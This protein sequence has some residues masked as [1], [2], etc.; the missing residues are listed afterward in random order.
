MSSKPTPTDWILFVTL[1]VTWGTSFLFIEIAL[2]SIPPL[3]IAAG[4]LAIAAVVLTAV[5]YILRLRLPMQGSIWWYFLVIGIVGNALPFF[6]IS[7]GQQRIDSGLAG[8]LI[9]V[10]PL[11][12]LVLA[13][14]FIPGEQMTSRKTFGFVVGFCG[15]AVMMG[16]EALL[17]LGGSASALAHQLAV[18]TAALCYS[19]NAIVARRMPETHPIVAS[20]GAMIMASIVMVPVA[21]ALDTPWNLTIG[22]GSLAVLGSLG[23]ASTAAG[24]IVFFALIRS[25]G[26]TFYSLVNYPIPIVA[27]ILGGAVLSEDPGWTTVAALTLVLIGIALSQLPSR[28]ENAER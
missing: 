24:T 26:P 2:I 3:S 8:I 9:G 27:V 19:A 12:T 11:V 23:L 17:E 21:G 28:R 15:I 18:L 25:A 22:S 10:V 14:F 7:W 1:V 5:V 13:H 6:L 20:A 16:P 4:R